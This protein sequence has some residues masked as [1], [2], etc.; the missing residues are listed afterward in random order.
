M[1]RKFS[2]FWASPSIFISLS[3]YPFPTEV[4]FQLKSVFH[5][6]E[7]LGSARTEGNH[8]KLF[9]WPMKT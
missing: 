7:T 6:L 1:T 8:T 5:L 9:L 2:R 4:I 3:F